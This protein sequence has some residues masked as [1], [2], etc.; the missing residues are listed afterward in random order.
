MVLGKL[1][2]ADVLSKP[3]GQGLVQRLFES[4]GVVFVSRL[5]LG[6]G[7]GGGC[8]EFDPLSRYRPCALSEPKCSDA[9]RIR[10][11]FGSSVELCAPF[12][13]TAA[14]HFV[15]FC[16]CWLLLAACCL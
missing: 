2:P 10:G 12:E 4:S 16:Y 11:H 5:E 15:L 8:R 1:N 6:L 3:L 13:E 9:L 14:L 7:A